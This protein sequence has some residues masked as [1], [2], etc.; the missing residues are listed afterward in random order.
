MEGKV[1]YKKWDTIQK[2]YDD[3][4]ND[5]SNDDK[6]LRELGE[7]LASAY[8]ID[9][10]KASDMWQDIIET[11]I[12]EDK[13]NVE[14][15]I[16]YIFKN[17]ISRRLDYKESAE[18]ISL[19]SNR[20][21]LF[22][23]YGLKSFCSDAG[24]FIKYIL[25]GFLQQNN[26]LEASNFFELYY[27]LCNDDKED[28]EK[29]YIIS[30]VEE[31]C[32]GQNYYKIKQETI[33]GFLDLNIYKK[34]IGHIC[35][36]LKVIYELVDVEDY[37][38]F[39][40]YAKKEG[41][42]KQYADILWVA[43]E[44]Y[45]VSEIRDKWLDY[46]YFNERKMSLPYIYHSYEDKESI[47]KFYAEVLSDSDELID[48]Y[49][50][51]RIISEIEK[52]VL[53]KWIEEE[54]WEYYIKNLYRLIINSWYASISN[55]NM[56][57]VIKGPYEYNQLLRERNVWEWEKNNTDYK[58]QISEKT[59]K[60]NCLE[61]KNALQAVADMLKGKKRYKQEKKYIDEFIIKINEENNFVVK[62]YNENVYS[63]DG[64]LTYCDG[65]II[66]K[67]DE[68]INKDD[69]I[70]HL[71]SE[72]L[73]QNNYIFYRKLY[74]HK[75]LKHINKGL[76]IL[77]ICRHVKE[78]IYFTTKINKNKIKKVS[79]KTIRDTSYKVPLYDKLQ[80]EHKKDVLSKMIMQKSESVMDYT[81][82]GRHYFTYNSFEEWINHL[83][84]LKYFSELRKQIKNKKK[85]D[86]WTKDFCYKSGYNYNNE[87]SGWPADVIYEI[88]KEVINF[89]L[90][91]KESKYDVKINIKGNYYYDFL[92]L[93]TLTF[94]LE[95]MLY[96][97]GVGYF[98]I[99][100]LE[101]SIDEI[102]NW[103]EI[104]LGY[105]RKTYYGNKITEFAYY[106]QDEIYDLEYCEEI[107]KGNINILVNALINLEK[108]ICAYFRYKYDLYR[109]K[110]AQE[111]NEFRKLY[112]KL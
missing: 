57:E 105:N 98:S 55:I 23:L 39:F 58:V 97:I 83:R 37:E 54:K 53:W 100:E 29:K 19:D 82:M 18:F 28:Y 95:T 85:R 21:K 89:A 71:D 50:D 110:Y 1:K 22:T 109:E 46:N 35:S 16:V 72:I 14:F 48:Y 84:N 93:I 2:K 7:I 26:I 64:E 3:I 61:Y 73:H 44:S 104:N 91:Y 24:S 62:E 59:R 32:F 108:R 43:R 102:V 107:T 45:S 51:S 6:V 30:A 20:M 65:E 49:F 40:E 5:T 79:K 103:L 67:D 106:I 27:S 69:E 76:D 52:Y 13:E 112:V 9:K 33:D 36:L 56:E 15:Y 8:K 86:G 11:K 80:I 75:R 111:A 60:K 10:K 77:F 87:Y 31:L 38:P 101:Y 66:N 47:I 99:Y 41:L 88:P 42:D 96:G 12:D 94:S 70:I 68:I 81:Y 25:I 74:G 4:K 92:K 90:E 34:D 78:K 17:I 63:M